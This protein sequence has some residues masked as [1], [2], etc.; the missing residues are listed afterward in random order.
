VGFDEKLLQRNNFSGK[1]MTQLKHRA[2]NGVHLSH[3]A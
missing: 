2:Q 3:P 1:T